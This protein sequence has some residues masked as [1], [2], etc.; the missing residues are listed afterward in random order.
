M[1][2]KGITCLS[3]LV[4]GMIIAMIIG[5]GFVIGGLTG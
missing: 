1:I 3:L 4:V 5:A 2:P